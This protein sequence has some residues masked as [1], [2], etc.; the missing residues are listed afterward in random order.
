MG[1]RRN[2]GNTGHRITQ[3]RDQVID[4]AAGQLPAF[5]WL[6]TLR[7]FNLNHFSIGQIGWRHTKAT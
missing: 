4:L 5:T 2:Q 1:R 7:H 3:T 6:G